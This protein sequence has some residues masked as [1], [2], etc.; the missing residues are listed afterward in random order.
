M[1]R[2]RS[3]CAFFFHAVLLDLTD[4][5]MSISRPHDAGGQQN[6]VQFFYK[7]GRMLFILR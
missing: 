7:G 5:R 1:C 2:A 4:A 6:Q 3:G